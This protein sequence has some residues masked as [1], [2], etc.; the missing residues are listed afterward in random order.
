MS[1]YP[2][3]KKYMCSEKY[4]SM[5]DNCKQDYAKNKGAFSKWG[6]DFDKKRAFAG[7]LDNEFEKI[8]KIADKAS[9]TIY[10]QGLATVSAYNFDRGGFVLYGIEPKHA[11]NRGNK[12]FVDEYAKKYSIFKYKLSGNGKLLKMNESKA[13]QYAKTLEKSAYRLY[14]VYK[15]RLNPLKAQ[16][17]GSAQAQL[18]YYSNPP[19]PKSVS[20]LVKETDKILSSQMDFF[21]DEALTKKAFSL[22]MK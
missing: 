8:F 20:Q 4:L 10:Y 6:S 13:E 21:Y 3:H 7:Y 15:V 9:H 12:N 1:T 16:I 14:Y 17:I 2:V 19:K 22:P 11:A 18:E 5:G